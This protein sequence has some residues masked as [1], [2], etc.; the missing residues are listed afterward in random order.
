V[1]AT[2]AQTGVEKVILAMTKAFGF[3]PSGDD[4]RSPTKSFSLSKAFRRSFD[5]R[6][7]KAPKMTLSEIKL[8]VELAVQDLNGQDADRLRFKI[9]GCR[10]AND[11]WLLRSDL[12]QLVAKR[13]SQQEAAQ[14]I[15]KLL[16]CFEGWLPAKNL[17]A[18]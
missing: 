1:G 8:Q 10:E 12:H 13:F 7:T 9:R 11:L 14:R 4:S 18:I 17:T 15:N 6:L 16:P 2:S 5:P 3:E